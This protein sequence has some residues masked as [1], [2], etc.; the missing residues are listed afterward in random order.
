MSIAPEQLAQYGFAN[1]GEAFDFIKNLLCGLIRSKP[2]LIRFH[3]VL[4]HFPDRYI[5]IDG[6]R[7]RGYEELMNYI[8]VL[9][10]GVGAVN[11]TANA[12]V[13]HFRNEGYWFV[14]LRDE[15]VVSD[16]QAISFV[17]LFLQGLVRR[18]ASS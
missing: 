14:S 11:I 5:S 13:E 3:Q 6:I 12:I 18:A 2:E 10:A 8:R 7:S 16:D 1:R 17:S 4:H 15:R 9:G